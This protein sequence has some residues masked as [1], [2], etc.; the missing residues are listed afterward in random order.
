MTQSSSSRR[1]WLV[2]TLLATIAIVAAVFIERARDDHPPTLTAE[3]I[4]QQIGLTN[5]VTGMLNG[6]D[7]A[8]IPVG[9]R[10]I[11]TCPPSIPSTMEWNT[12]VAFASA[13][14]LRMY[15]YSQDFA[16]EKNP[17]ARVWSGRKLSSGVSAA[18]KITTLQPSR[19]YYIRATSEIHFR[20][21]V[22]KTIF[23]R[24]EDLDAQRVF[25]LN[26]DIATLGTAI[27]VMAPAGDLPGD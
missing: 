5:V 27:F 25:H 24:D 11:I 22:D 21:A 3:I 26:R 19:T 9:K 10:G 7:E 4:E 16:A 2:L 14:G 8:V 6:S 17:D 15:E 18:E 12:A 20:C 1:I 13:T 23:V